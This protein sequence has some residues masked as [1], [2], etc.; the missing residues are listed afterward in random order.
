MGTGG[1]GYSGLFF[2]GKNAT[3]TAPGAGGGADSYSETRGGVGG[4][5]GTFG[6][7]GGA[8]QTAPK[9]N[10]FKGA[11]GAGGAGGKAIALNGKTVTYINTGTI[12]GAVA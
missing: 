4:S 1:L 2:N 3:E 10:T 8:G 5:G 7:T 12:N 11:G 9:G 6:N